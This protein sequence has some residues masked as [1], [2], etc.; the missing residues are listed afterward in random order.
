M[1]SKR[2]LFRVTMVIILVVQ[3]IIYVSNDAET[4]HLHVEQTERQLEAVAHTE[5]EEV[6][7]S[8]F[9]KDFRN[10]DLSLD[11]KIQAWKKIDDEELAESLSVDLIEA[12]TSELTLA[13]ALDKGREIW[14]LD[15]IE[16]VE[17]FVVA[18][19]LAD[20]QDSLN[21]LIETDLS[22]IK[23][24][25]VPEL[26]SQWAVEDIRAVSNWLSRQESSPVLDQA[27][28]LYAHVIKWAKPDEAKLWAS[29]I[30]DGEYRAEV[31]A[32]IENAL[33][34]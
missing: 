23:E 21:W 26:I 17:E 12:I 6:R 1:R 4:P 11:D 25:L 2:V 34:E 22:E 7:E 3:G 29:R 19:F 33:G 31:E 10:E 15:E 28:E 32:Q 13:E 8:S 5:N 9:L 27:I 14:S 18:R 16:R 20:P 30:S 24:Q